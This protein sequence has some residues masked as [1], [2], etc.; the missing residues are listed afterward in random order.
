MVVVVV[1]VVVLV[2][3]NRTRRMKIRPISITEIDINTYLDYND[4]ILN[5]FFFLSKSD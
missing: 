2:R 4:K 5:L 1:P 3:P